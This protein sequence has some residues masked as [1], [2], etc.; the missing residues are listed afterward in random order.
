MRLEHNLRNE[1]ENQIILEK[2]KFRHVHLGFFSF[3]RMEYIKWDLAVKAN[4]NY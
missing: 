1:N 3:M 2:F 4:N